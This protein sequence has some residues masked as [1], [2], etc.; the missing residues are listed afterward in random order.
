[1]ECYTY[2]VLGLKN[3]KT[4]RKIVSDDI[5]YILLMNPK[6]WANL[7]FKYKMNLLNRTF[8]GTPNS[9]HIENIPVIPC[10]PI[11]IIN[12]ICSTVL[13]ECSGCFT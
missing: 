5:L 12:E 8:Q 6:F 13:R 4:H 7:Y 11:F 9:M 3:I 1:M 10:V 2:L